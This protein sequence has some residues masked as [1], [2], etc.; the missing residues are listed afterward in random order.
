M[1]KISTKLTKDAT[2]LPKHKEGN[3][4]LHLSGE[5][6]QLIKIASV[7]TLIHTNTGKYIADS[8]YCPG[9]VTESEWAQI[10]GNSAGDFKLVRAINI[11]AIT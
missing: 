8:L 7:H 2:Q 10:T 11:E 3:W 5:L 9:E 1:T 4:Y 6:Y